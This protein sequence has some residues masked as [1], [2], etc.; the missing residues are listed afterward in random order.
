MRRDRV[1]G[2]HSRQS[3]EERTMKRDGI[4]T[5]ILWVL[6]LSVVVG[7][8]LTVAGEQIFGRREVSDF[9]FYMALLCAAL[10]VFFRLLGRRAGGATHGGRD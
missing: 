2:R 6:V 10:Y 8:V 3:S 1:V 4:Y 7:A 9:G 5:A